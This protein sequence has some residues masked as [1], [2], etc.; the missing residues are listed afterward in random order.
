MTYIRA[1]G[2]LRSSSTSKSLWPLQ[3]KV[4]LFYLLVLKEYIFTQTLE[5]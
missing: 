5:F 2:A 4:L 1:L 3:N